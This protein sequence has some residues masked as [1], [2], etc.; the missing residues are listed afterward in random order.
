MSKSTSNFRN[1]RGQVLVRGGGT[2]TDGHGWGG[3]KVLKY[4]AKNSRNKKA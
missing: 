1:L 2:K 4:K 3:G